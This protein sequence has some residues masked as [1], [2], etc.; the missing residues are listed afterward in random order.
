MS[1]FIVQHHKADFNAAKEAQ[2]RASEQLAE[3]NN[4]LT[5][6]KSLDIEGLRKSAADWQTK[7]EQAERDADARV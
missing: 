4:E 3:V 7:A 2:R 6:Y 1:T 5:E